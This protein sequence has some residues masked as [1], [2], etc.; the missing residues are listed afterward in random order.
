MNTFDFV[1]PAKSNPLSA[2][3]DMSSP[4]PAAKKSAEPFDSLMNRALARPIRAREEATPADSSTPAAK[5]ESGAARKLK[6][7]PRPEAGNS[8]KAAPTDSSNAIAG[9]AGTEVSDKDSTSQDSESAT[10]ATSADETKKSEP[11]Q[12]APT[13]SAASALQSLVTIPLIPLMVNPVGSPGGASLAVNSVDAAT[14]AS[15]VVSLATSFNLPDAEGGGRGVSPAAT[16][17]PGS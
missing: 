4:P 17:W 1:L 7:S 16:A 3:R 12:A 6:P 13:D 9:K 15:P 10:A 11:K 14:V 2:D 8:G 5:R